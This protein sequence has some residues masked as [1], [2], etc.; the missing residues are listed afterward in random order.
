M[1]KKFD[2]H[3]VSIHAKQKSIKVTF[4]NKKQDLKNI[5][6]EKINECD[7]MIVEISQM[8]YWLED[9]L[10]KIDKKPSKSNHFPK[11]HKENYRQV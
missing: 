4:M 2:R 6:L 5:L 8:R 1:L 10:K 7:D 11:L 3:I 9:L